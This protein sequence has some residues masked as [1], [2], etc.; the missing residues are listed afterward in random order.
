[1][2]SNLTGLLTIGG[3][4][5][6]LTGV[7]VCGNI[8]GRGSRIKVIQHYHNTESNAVEAV[9]KFPLPEGSSIFGFRVL[10]D[11]KTIV[12]SVEERDKAFEIYDEALAEGMVVIFLMKSVPTYSHCLSA[13]LIPAAM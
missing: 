4:A 13:T 12:G 11:G 7:D 3:S 8:T 9:Y 2:N 6:P 10:T 1:M 5:I